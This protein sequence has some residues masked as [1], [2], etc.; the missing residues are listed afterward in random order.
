MFS[1]SEMSVASIVQSKKI[2][3][4]ADEA[5]PEDDACRKAARRNEFFHIRDS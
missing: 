5:L 4:T 1:I 2:R 3:S